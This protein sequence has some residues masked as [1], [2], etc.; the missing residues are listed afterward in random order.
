MKKHFPPMLN[1]MRKGYV[2]CIFV[3]WILGIVLFPMYMPF[4][5][6]GLWDNLAA[7]S[8]V[9]IVYHA[10]NAV[11]MI[12][13]MQEHLSDAF[14]EVRYNAKGILKTV[15][16]ALGLMLAWTAICTLLFGLSLMID[17]FPVAEFTVALTA[18]FL[19]ENNPFFGAVCMTLLVPFGVCGLFYASGFCTVAYK[20]TKLAYPVVA[21]LLLLPHLF[22]ILWRGQTFDVLFTYVL[23][24]PIH[25]FACWS[26]QKTDC[27]WT[28]IFALSA[29]NLLAS[30]VCAFG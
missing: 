6:N 16:V 8:W 17:M 19:V 1:C 11:V 15:A 21:V 20:N 18:G 7:I 12:L 24:L 26:Y 4:I 30:A 3:Y 13:A 5:A 29:F 2:F 28:P 27:V 9:E 25:L 23:Q 22:D 14:F 10:I